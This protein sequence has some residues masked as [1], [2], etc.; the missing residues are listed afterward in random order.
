MQELHIESKI[1]NVP[2][3]MSF[4]KDGLDKLGCSEQIQTQFKMAVDELFGNIC[5]YAYDSGTGPVVITVGTEDDPASAV[6]V[7]CDEG[8]PYNPLEAD[9]PD[10]DLD[11]EDRPVGG[12]GIFLITEMMDDIIYEYKEGKNILK[13]IKKLS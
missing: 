2:E 9:V 11:I 12:L 10:I 13:I 5:Y 6:L 3:V 7:F 4:V 1:E 8:K